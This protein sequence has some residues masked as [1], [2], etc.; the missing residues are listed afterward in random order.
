MINVFAMS[1][2]VF[3]LFISSLWFQ[4]YLLSCINLFCI[5]CDLTIIDSRSARFNAEQVAKM[6]QSRIDTNQT[7]QSIVTQCLSI[8]SREPNKRNS[9][10]IGNMTW[11][12]GNYWLLMKCCNI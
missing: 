1:N 10:Y 4:M 6:V 7:S 3:I 5:L 8:Y 11:V 2:C 9:V 12:S